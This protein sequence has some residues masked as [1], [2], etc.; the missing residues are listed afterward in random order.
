T[1][2]GTLI[3][4]VSD[5]QGQALEGARVQLESSAL[6]GGAISTLTNDRGQWR[7]TRLPPG[8]YAIEIELSG[9]ATFGENDIRIGAE[10][11]LERTV[12]LKL[13]SVAESVVVEGSGSRI[14]A[15]GVGFSSSYGTDE[16]ASIPTRRSS[17]FDF[18]RA[19][20]GVSPTSPASGTV[21]TISAF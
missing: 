5:E 1:L 3:G 21:T 19:A 13:G 7:M 15:R 17:M 10:A 14:D 12:V 9:F 16:I 8:T 11:T 4:T 2:A 6:M 18:L 20:P